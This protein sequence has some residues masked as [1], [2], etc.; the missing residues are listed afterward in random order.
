MRFAFFATFFDRSA[1][2]KDIDPADHARV[3][4]LIADIPGLKRGLV[5]RAERTVG[6][7][8]PND[9]EP[10]Q[11]GLELYFDDVLAME[12]ALSRTGPMQALA[13]PDALPSI[14]GAEV[15]QQCMVIRQYDVPEP[16]AWG[17]REFCTFLVHYPG[18]AA[19]L[20][21]WLDHYVEHHTA[22]MKTFPGI[23]EIEVATRMDWIGFLPWARVDY[24]QRN[25]VVFDSGPALT[26][27]LESPVR[28]EMTKDFNSFPAF[29]GG[30]VHYPLL[31]REILR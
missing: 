21:L 13:A 7:N 5:Y 10:P 29:E 27:A 28:A 2:G 11:L 4:D 12:A 26:A 19:D 22:V 17:D 25:K 1:S 9:D 3:L 8:Y 16:T 15:Q 24:M 18:T 6:K 23:R 14:A 20:N 31:T 30:N